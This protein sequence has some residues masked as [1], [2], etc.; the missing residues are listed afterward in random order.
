MV[1][2]LHFHDQDICKNCVHVIHGTVVE[3]PRGKWSL[4]DGADPKIFQNLPAYLSKPP[5][6]KWKR[7]DSLLNTTC[8][9]AVYGLGKQCDSNKENAEP[10]TDI[11]SAAERELT[12]SD[13]ACRAA[14]FVADDYDWRRQ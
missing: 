7:R 12:L 9:G 13:R 6:K 3:T 10:A 1:C 2:D 4:I 5:P 14:T 11:E 8:Q